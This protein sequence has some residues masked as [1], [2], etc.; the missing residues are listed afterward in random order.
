ML[1][2]VMTF[3]LVMVLG[4]LTFIAVFMVSPH[5]MW[6]VLRG[7]VG[8][9][10]VPL[11]A[12]SVIADGH[13]NFRSP[14]PDGVL[15]VRGYMERGEPK[16]TEV[17]LLKD[18]RTEKFQ[19]D[20]L[21]ANL[22]AEYDRLMR[23][24]HEMAQPKQFFMADTLGGSKVNVSGRL[25]RNR[26]WQVERI[27][28][29]RSGSMHEYSRLDEVPSELRPRLAELIENQ[30]FVVESLPKY[31][32]QNG[33]LPVLDWATIVAFIGIAG[34]GGLAN[35]L[36]SNYSRDKGWGMG[37]RV[38]AIPSAIGGR[39]IALSHVGEV[40]DVDAANLARW[41]GWIRH[42]VRDQGIFVVCSFIGMALPCMMS[43]QFIR[44]ARVSSHAIAGMTAQGM[45]N[46]Y[47][48]YAD[49]FWT[50]T[51]LCGFLVLAPGQVSVS[52]QIARRWTDIIW[53]SSAWAKRMSGTQVK[54]LYYA[55]LGIY[56]LW[57][58]FILAYISN[59]FRILQIGAVLGN[60][61]LGAS[62]LQAWY[63][64]RVLL[65]RALQPHWFL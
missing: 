8:F 2:K 10:N 22:Q 7:F 46:E 27:D 41:R 31:V 40:F 34:A 29:M 50:L 16:L 20:K 1:E 18:A 3:K 32:V 42:V 52:D 24:A 43:L 57:G 45:A 48:S 15:I 33:R 39:T 61:A 47:P 26:S 56:C 5:N 13:F 44:N 54:Y 63:A 62:C 6:E 23:Q 55:I 60:V 38:G 51:L 12:E 65:P 28:L 4:Y 64:N 37:A 36:F 14:L 58:L 9:G 21:P 59:P 49:L 35:T 30:G 17:A 53:S 25:D 11:R 19:A